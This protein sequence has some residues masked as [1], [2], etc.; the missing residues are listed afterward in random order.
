MR[1]FLI[2]SLFLLHVNAKEIEA[3]YHVSYGIFG[4]V[5]TVRTDFKI[6]NNKTYIISV[7]ANTTGFAKSLSGDR[8]EFFQ[9]RGKVLE[10]GTLMPSV[11]THIV[12][13]MKK[14][15]GFVLNPNKWR[16]I[17]SKKVKITKFNKDKITQTRTKS[18]DGKIKSDSKNVLKYFVKD[19]LLS[20]FFNFKTQS[21]DYNITKST[22]FYAVGANDEDGRLDISPMSKEAQEDV[23]ESTKGHNFV[24]VI[25]KP[26]FASDKGELF[27]K[28]DD[29]GIG[30]MAV[31]K[32]VLFFGDIKAV[33]VKKNVR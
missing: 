13:R 26:I 2:L 14:K 17:L 11:Y 20:L 25:N 27:I 15:S 22:P 3:F 9:S 29:N 31:L 10:D 28:L 12:T 24:V 4:E 33:M 16:K 1:I 32:D 23:F 18:L 5:G 8:N 21:N 19:D 30:T 6:D 7:E